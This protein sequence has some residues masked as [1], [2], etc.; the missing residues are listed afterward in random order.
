MMVP[1]SSFLSTESNVAFSV[2]MTLPRSGKIA[3]KRL[4]LPCFADP[5]AESPSTKNNSLMVLSFDCAGDNL[6]DKETSF[7]LFI[8]PVRASS[9]AFLAA[10][11]AF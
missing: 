7:L 1:I 10:S 3:W 11:L 9:L 4:F 8:F 5:P 2:L 6:P